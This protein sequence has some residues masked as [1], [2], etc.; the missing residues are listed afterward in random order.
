MFLKHPRSH[1][2]RAVS[3][4]VLLV[5]MLALAAC[6]REGAPVPHATTN[7]AGAD[8]AIP[9]AG[10]PQDA[11]ADADA[12]ADTTPPNPCGAFPRPSEV[13]DDWED[14]P[15]Y[16]C[17]CPM[18]IPGAKGTLPPPIEWEPCPAAVPA[19][20]QCRWMKV[21]WSDAPGRLAFP[22]FS[23]ALSLDAQTGTPLLFF[24]RVLSDEPQGA[25][26]IVYL[27]A[28]VDGEVRA[29]FASTMDPNGCV[30]GLANAQE[31]RY[32]V[33]V[34]DPSFEGVIVGALGARP[35]VKY[36]AAINPELHSDWEVSADWI[37]RFKSR[38]TM[39]SWNLQ[40]TVVPYDQAK[41]PDGMPALGYALQGKDFFWE[42]GVSSYRGIMSWNPVDGA[43]PLV[44]WFGDW[45]QAAGNFAT[46]GKDMVWEYGKDQDP[47][48]PNYL[49]RSIMTA[50]YTTDPALA[51]STARRLR[52]DPGSFAVFPYV[53]G[54][55]H[56]VRKV[57]I[58]G[59]DLLIVRL[60]DGVSWTLYGDTAANQYAFS[61]M[62]PVGVT[63][64]DIFVTAQV[65]PEP[66][67][68]LRIP[69]SAL[70]PGIPPD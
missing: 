69:L 6:R 67:Q 26:P 35:A 13:P 55:G 38:Y 53:V 2:S 16:G 24:S 51:Q 48:G 1:A 52:S 64:N 42:V 45:T 63:C 41:D 9:D 62:Q 57:S 12:D 21:T 22:W 60:S 14:F 5:A 3:A 70:G 49:T 18:F 50:P 20:L 28:E 7:D 11:D 56:A 39:T 23:P 59:N 4:N 30:V 25:G 33:R 58:T 37:V 54:C 61:Y 40:T 10:A 36:K 34:T 17:D 8:A 19:A 68:I 27:V 44:R 66:R 15:D 43:R 32:A 47:N 31:N 65:P 46:D 29:A